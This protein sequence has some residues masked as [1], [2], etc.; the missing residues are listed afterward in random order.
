MNAGNA[1]RWCLCVA[2]GVCCN[3]G[4]ADRIARGGSTPPSLSYV[5]CI[6]RLMFAINDCPTEGH[7]GDT[8]AVRMLIAIGRPALEPCLDMMVSSDNKESRYHCQVVIGAVTDKIV[9]RRLGIDLDIP[10][11]ADKFD[12]CQANEMLVEEVHSKL[13]QCMGNL[14]YSAPRG[15]IL[16]SAT[17]WKDWL[18]KHG[19]DKRNKF[20]YGLVSY[21][22][23]GTRVKPGAFSTRA[24]GRP[25]SG[26]TALVRDRSHPDLIR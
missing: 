18:N 8:P 22:S 15:Q 5:D 12:A 19:A 17:K 10:V 13:W 1:I 7:G 20:N 21:S 26:A 24:A 11:A 25:V 23:T 16:A 9:Q 2:L 4:V 3:P 6:A 14:D